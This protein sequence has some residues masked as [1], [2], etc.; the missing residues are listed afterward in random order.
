MVIGQ[1]VQEI[2]KR[3]KAKQDTVA[4]LEKSLNEN[5][6]RTFLWA[7]FALDL[8]DEDLRTA[9]GD[10]QRILAELP[11]DL[12]ATYE[13]FLR[14]I[15]PGKEGFAIKLLRL[16]IGSYRPLSLDEVNIIVNMEDATNAGCQNIKEFEKQYLGTNIT[17]DIYKVLGP[18][19]RISE[20]KVY[21]VHISLKEFLCTSICQLDDRGLS[22][23][24]H[25]D[26]WDAHLYLASACTAYLMLDDFATDL[27]ATHRSSPRDRSLDSQSESEAREEQEMRSTPIRTLHWQVNS[28][29]SNTQHYIGL[30][31]LPS[32]KTL[33]LRRLEIGYSISQIGNRNIDSRIGSSFTA[34]NQDSHCPVL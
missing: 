33:L 27:F 6:D 22:N 17:A 19:V 14:R 7:K 23:R 29:S 11:Q 25:V 28:S 9:P 24:F 1:R 18:L 4:L 21:L 20:S 13:R 31:T 12:Q 16:M 32:V 30:G 10:F 2:A 3:T 26:L 34:S 15:Q 8:L 5:A